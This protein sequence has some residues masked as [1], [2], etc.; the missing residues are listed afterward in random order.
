MGMYN[1]FLINCPQCGNELSFQSKAG[2]L[3]FSTYTIN[4][5][6][7]IM[8]GDLDNEKEICNQC[9]EQITISAKFLI[10]ANI[11]KRD[12]INEHK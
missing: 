5:I 10:F 3:D 1:I 11:T 6:P 8:A 9:K 7:A 12:F 4:D 2:I